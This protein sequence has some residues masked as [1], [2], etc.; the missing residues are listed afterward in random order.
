MDPS[1]PARPLLVTHDTELLDDLLRLAAAAGVE[2]TVAHHAAQAV[3]EWARAPLI[4]VGADLLSAAAALDPDPRRHVVVAGRGADARE[5]P[6]WEAAL[7]VGAEA[8]LSLPADESRLAGLLTE[9]AHGRA[10]LSPV[11][12]VV[13][14]RGGAGASLLALALAMAAQRRGLHA[15]LVDADP[16]GSGLDTLLGSE[17]VAGD[18]W[19]DLVGRQGR[20]N[21]PAL[22]ARLPDVRGA[23]LVTWAQG[24]TA[25][26]PPAAMRAVLACAA[27]GADLVVADLPRASEPASDEAL[28]R[29]SVVLLVVPSELPA[30]FAAARLVPRL[31]RAARDLRLVVRENGTGLGADDV[32]RTLDLPVGARLGTDRALLR[33]AR[34]GTAAAGT[35]SSPL[36]DCADR[37]LG[38]LVPAN[39]P[40]PGRT[41]A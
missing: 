9:S 16:L 2:P 37:L 26:V 6:V 7:R 8:V 25:A 1:A 17:D 14:G 39:A 10:E 33:D 24:T 11:V 27:R 21:W 41:P 32:A 15:A 20:L 19:G 31:R 35:R 34:R 4:V 13:G 38:G 12:S 23:A 3:P 28:R 29:S 30:V 40:T 36:T 5:G 18:R 22:R